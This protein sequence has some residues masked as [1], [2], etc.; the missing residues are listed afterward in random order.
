MSNF[1]LNVA[2]AQLFAGIF[3]GG[4]DK[5]AIILCVLLFGMPGMT[6]TLLPL[7]LHSKLVLVGIRAAKLSWSTAGGQ[8]DAQ[9]FR[10]GHKEHSCFQTEC[11]P[12]LEA[13]SFVPSVLCSSCRQPAP[14]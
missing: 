6:G 3:F 1:F 2:V 8:T 13:G 9:V 12:Q 11:S 4:E 5:I 7:L 10:L 14:G